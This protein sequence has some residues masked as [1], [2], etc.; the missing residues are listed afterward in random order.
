MDSLVG[1]ETVQDQLE[2]LL[3]ILFLLPLECDV[4]HLS[5]DGLRD[6]FNVNRVDGTILLKFGYPRVFIADGVV[7]SKDIFLVKLAL[8]ALAAQMVRAQRAHSAPRV[9]P[10]LL[11]DLL[12]PVFQLLYELDYVGRALG[13]FFID[14][15]VQSLHRALA[16][17]LSLFRHRH[18]CLKK[19]RP[20]LEH[21]SEVGWRGLLCCNRVFVDFRS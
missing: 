15:T 8:L 3:L 16:K 11:C 21:C 7:V 12:A 10:A 17:L 20:R 6:L 18:K 1:S 19:L 9:G 13:H 2:V 14:Q 4:L 5:H